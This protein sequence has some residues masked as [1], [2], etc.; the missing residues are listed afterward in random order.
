MDR[1][2]WSI[3]RSNIEYRNVWH[4]SISSDSSCIAIGIDGFDTSVKTTVDRGYH[5]VL[6][7]VFLKDGVLIKNIR[8]K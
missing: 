3:G 1:N 5:V 7:E 6:M 8:F 2:Y 4:V